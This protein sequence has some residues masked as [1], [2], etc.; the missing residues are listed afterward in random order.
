MSIVYLQFRANHANVSMSVLE[1]TYMSCVMRKLA[2]VYAQLISAFV[3]VTLQCRY[4]LNQFQT[5]NQLLYDCLWQCS[6]V[7]VEPFRKLRKHVS[8][9]EAH[10]SASD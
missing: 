4:F 8:R 6:L 10:I 5:S 7:Y 2:F 1:S 9:D 3:Y